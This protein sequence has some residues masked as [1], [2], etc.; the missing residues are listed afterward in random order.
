MIKYTN[1][2]D[3]ISDKFEK[4]VNPFDLKTRLNWFATQFDS[5][6]HQNDWPW[7]RTEIDTS[8]LNPD[9]AAHRILITLE[10][11]GYIR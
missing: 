8:K 4:W 5:I 10:K 6:D 3:T 9:L 7:H 2:F 11:L 1:Y